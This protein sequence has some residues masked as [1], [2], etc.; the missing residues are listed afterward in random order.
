MQLLKSGNFNDSLM[1]SD[2]SKFYINLNLFIIT[3]L[4][5]K[6][7]KIHFCYLLFNAFWYFAKIFVILI[8]IY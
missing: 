5:Q 8:N 4:I 6:N 3:F 7:V 1:W 2:K